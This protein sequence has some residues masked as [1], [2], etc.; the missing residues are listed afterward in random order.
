MKLFRISV[1]WLLVLGLST[2]AFAGD[3]LESIARATQQQAQT[4]P[5]KIDKAYLWPGAA[6][7]VAGMSMAVYGFLHTSGGDFV[8]GEVSKESMT[9]LGGA[10]LGIAGLGGA[11]L[12]LGS[13]HARTAPAITI[14]PGR[15]TLTKQIV[16]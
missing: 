10:G 14:R 8:S 11:I 7:F 5:Q 13:Q 15:A 2:T 9:G 16:W 1:A 3:L 12:Y 4:Q 6:L